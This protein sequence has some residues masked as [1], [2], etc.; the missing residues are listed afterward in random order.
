MVSELKE[1]YGLGLILMLVSSVLLF[2]NAV[3]SSFYEPILTST[4]YKSTLAVFALGLFVAI[5]ENL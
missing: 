1:E 2:S 4:L 5:I 3:V